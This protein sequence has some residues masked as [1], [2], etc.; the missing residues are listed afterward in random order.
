MMIDKVTQR[1][2]SN[3]KNLDEVLDVLEFW[4]DQAKIGDSYEF[5]FWNKVYQFWVADS[6]KS[7]EPQNGNYPEIRDL[8][9][10]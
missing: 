2:I 10:K 9:L 6:G 3:C 7:D 8:K 1:K 5:L 4:I